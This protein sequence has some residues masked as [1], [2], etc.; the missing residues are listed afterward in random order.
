MMNNLRIVFK[1]EW[2][3][4]WRD[5]KSLRMTLLMPV[6]F[7]AIFAASTLFAIHMGKQS[8][9]TNTESIKL[10]VVGAEQLPSLTSWLQERGVKV[11]P[12]NEDA[13]QRVEQGKLDYALI[14]PK[15]AA[16]NFATGE[17]VELALVF[18]MTNNKIHG[19]LGFIRQQIWSWNSRMGSL[20]L[21][22]RGISPG[23]IN[24]VYIRDLNIA[25]D[26]KMGFFVMMSLPM[27]LILT[28]FM[29]SVGFTAD[30]VAGERERRSL[31][32][33][34]IT[35]VKSEALI[36][37]KW[38]NSYSLTLTVLF[39]EMLLLAVA[40]YY[41]PFNELGLRVNVSP[42]DL[43]GVFFVLAS[44][45]LIATGLQF[46]ISIFARSFKDAQTYMGLMVFIPMVPLFYTLFN[47]SAY[48]EW[49]RW[50]PILGH[51]VLIKDFLLGGQVQLLQVAQ[52]WLISLVPGALLL[53]LT[54]R[55][56]RKPKIVYGIG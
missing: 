21:L 10:S 50:V 31:E 5:K 9:A 47:P 19:S 41:L 2:R 4:T 51:Q 42:G 15:G 28:A 36:A 23:V 53:W 22:S 16:E 18:D 45:A 43:L 12:V 6:Y 48:A 34:L 35:P 8:R 52:V 37:G 3:D 39:I 13:Y 26:E 30:M 20:R 14:I 49:Y 17:S 33:L 7:V 29:S 55:Q 54:T 27:L 25:S 44:M 40:F 1:K 38:L 56:L 11:E 32:S 46:L 24:P